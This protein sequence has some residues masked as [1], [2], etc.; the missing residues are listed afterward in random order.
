MAVDPVCGMEIDE[1]TA[2]ELGAEVVELAGRRYYFCCPPCRDEFLRDPARYLDRT[3][4]HPGTA[5]R[6]GGAR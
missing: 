3:R 1:R 2:E 6:P 5:A 4:P